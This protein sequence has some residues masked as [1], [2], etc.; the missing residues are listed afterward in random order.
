MKYL[1]MKFYFSTCLASDSDFSL[2]CDQE[3]CLMDENIINSVN[4]GENTWVAG[5]YS[6]FWG[7]TRF[8][9]YNFYLGTFL[10]SDDAFE[11]LIQNF[12]LYKILIP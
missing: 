7:E 12:H 9:G 10:P 2:S 3:I 4:S 1:N 8:D 11:A 6:F 5:N